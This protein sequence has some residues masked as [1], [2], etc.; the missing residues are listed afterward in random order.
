MDRVLLV[1]NP[2]F[3]ESFC[4]VSQ[5]ELDYS[6]KNIFRDREEFSAENNNM[7]RNLLVTKFTKT[8]S[9]FTFWTRVTV[10]GDQTRAGELKFMIMSK[11]NWRS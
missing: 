4:L 9:L 3:S 7:S 1:N 8:S 6:Q 11:I 10:E 2:T 5:L